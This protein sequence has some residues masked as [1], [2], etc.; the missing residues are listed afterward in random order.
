MSDKYSNLQSRRNFLR[1]AVYH[2]PVLYALGSI[3]DPTE[4]VADAS[5]G[6]AGPPGNGN[7]YGYGKSVVAPQP[8]RTL[9]F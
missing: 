9:R 4:I 2:A 3:V 1:K 5:G 6:P 7:G 8:R